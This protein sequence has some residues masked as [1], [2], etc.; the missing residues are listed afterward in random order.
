MTQRRWHGIKH[1]KKPINQLFKI[2]ITIFSQQIYHECIWI[3]PLFKVKLYFLSALFMV[4][5][6]L[7]LNLVFSPIIPRDNFSEVTCYLV[8]WLRYWQ[9][10]WFISY[11]QHLKRIDSSKDHRMDN[12]K[13]NRS[14]SEFSRYIILSSTS[15]LNII[16]NIFLI[17]HSR[18]Y[19]HIQNN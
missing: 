14:K 10:E 11:A 8:Y 9:L 16:D 7:W 19:E 3:I 12:N 5:Q 2:N 17:K 1:F 4:S 13:D 6:R 18:R 15:T